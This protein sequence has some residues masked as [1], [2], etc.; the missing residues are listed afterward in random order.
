[1][2]TESKHTVPYDD[3]HMQ[4]HKITEICKV[5][6]LLIEDRAA[7][8]TSITCDLFM[9][10]ANSFREHMDL[11]DRSIY[12]RLLA[13]QDRQVNAEASRS[14]NASKELKR[15]FNSYMSKWCR[16]GLS[17]KDHPAF[18]AETREI[19]NMIQDRIQVETEQL[20]PMMRQLEGNGSKVANA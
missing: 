1:M 4:N 17:I 9:T 20:Y 19:F 6:S 7:C 16:Q 10:F 14:L 5:L 12:A 2:K 11:E 8:D 3:L 18:I 13:H 15:I